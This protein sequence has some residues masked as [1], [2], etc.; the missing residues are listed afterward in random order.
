MEKIL[1]KYKFLKIRKGFDYDILTIDEK[2]TGLE[3]SKEDKKYI[4]DKVYQEVYDKGGYMSIRQMG[5]T[6]MLMKW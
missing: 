3:L 5:T 2:A 1:Q 6:L 4:M